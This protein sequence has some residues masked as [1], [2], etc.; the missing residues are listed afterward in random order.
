MKS[1]FRFEELLEPHD[2]ALDIALKPRLQEGDC[3]PRERRPELEGL[4]VVDGGST[5]GLVT[6]EG[7]FEAGDE[8]GPQRRPTSEL[9]RE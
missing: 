5:A 1:S 8:T 9:Q 4:A 6:L 3:K 7:P 2:L